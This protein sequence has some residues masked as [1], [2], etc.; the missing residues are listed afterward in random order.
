MVLTL[1]K[2]G[3]LENR[4]RAAIAATKIDPKAEVVD[5]VLA[6]SA[7]GTVTAEILAHLSDQAAWSFLYNVMEIRKQWKDQPI[8]EA[9]RDA[10]ALQLLE[11]M[12]PSGRA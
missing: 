9:Q 11:Q 6:L 4:I 3:G 10:V 1:N 2:Q 8:V 12:T 5:A 7:L